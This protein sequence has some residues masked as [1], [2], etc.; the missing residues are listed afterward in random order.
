M[1]NHGTNTSLHKAAL[2]AGAALLIMSIFSGS[3]VV[4]AICDVLGAWALYVRS[5]SFSN[6][7]AGV[8]PCLD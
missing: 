3:S 5:T 4:V 1:T 7:Q 8:S 2:L 6:R